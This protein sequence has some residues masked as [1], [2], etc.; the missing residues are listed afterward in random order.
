[1]SRSTIFLAALCVI[2]GAVAAALLVGRGRD[3]A[4]PRVAQLQRRLDAVEHRAAA[5]LAPGV[6]G[7]VLPRDEAAASAETRL[8]RGSSPGLPAVPMSDQQVLPAFVDAAAAAER[9]RYEAGVLEQT[10]SSEQLDVAASNTFAA[11]LS[12]AFGAAPELAGNQLVD[13]ECRTSLCRI[14]VLQRNDDDV[15]SFL[16]SV[17]SL[18]GL[19]NTDTYWQRELNG[20]GSSVMTMYVARPGHELPDYRMRVPDGPADR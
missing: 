18:P 1:M 14:A 16:S 9:R 20:D 15:D 11:G 8:D 7:T 6:P 5:P 4:D 12:Q 2:G 19:E 10:L 3:E 13:A 17:G